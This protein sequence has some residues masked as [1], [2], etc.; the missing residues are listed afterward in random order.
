MV[1]ASVELADKHLW[2]FISAPQEQ[3]L[4]VRRHAETSDPS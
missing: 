3:A 4:S 2:Q 1:I